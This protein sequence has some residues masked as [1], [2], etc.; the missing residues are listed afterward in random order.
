MEKAK[1]IAESLK[2]EIEQLGEQYN[3]LS[4]EDLFTVWFM[5]AF[6]TP[7]NDIAANSL[8]NISNDKGNDAILIDDAR[9]AVFVVQT[10]YHK[11]FNS[12][13]ENRSDVLSFADLSHIYSDRDKSYYNEIRKKMSK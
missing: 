6:L 2:V 13:N 5:R 3:K 10:K 8:V 7:N 12:Y 9:K 1:A 4:D 11:K